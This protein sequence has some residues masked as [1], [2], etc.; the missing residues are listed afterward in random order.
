[1]S[2]IARA[3]LIVAGV[4]TSWL[5]AKDATNFG[6]IQMTITVL[7]IMLLVFAA[8]FWPRWRPKQRP[9]SQPNTSRSS[10]IAPPPAK[11]K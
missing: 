2:W 3:A 8:A 11:T 6:V 9:R 10:A 4:M 7:L 5:V 1:L